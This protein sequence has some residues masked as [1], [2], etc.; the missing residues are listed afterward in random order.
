M[1]LR[2]FFC[3]INSVCFFFSGGSFRRFRGSDTAQPKA[4]GAITAF[5]VVYSR[6]KPHSEEG[7]ECFHCFRIPRQARSHRVP[8]DSYRI[9]VTDDGVMFQCLQ[10][11]NISFM[12]NTALG[13][14]HSISEMKDLLKELS[15]QK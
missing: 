1:K 2:T 14:M 15:A 5:H 9:S 10:A 7:N 8:G 13:L 12:E 11:E 4:A 3:V 6:G